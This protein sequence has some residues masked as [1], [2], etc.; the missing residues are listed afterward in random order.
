MAGRGS[1]MLMISQKGTFTQNVY[2]NFFTFA[3]SVR[4]K[5]LI[6]DFE[7][8][9]TMTYLKLSGKPF[10]YYL[11]ALYATDILFQQNNEPCSSTEKVCFYLNTK[12]KLCVRQ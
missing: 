6:L 12:R 9:K 1:T 2:P 5:T 3:S 4:Y 10:M 7:K 11:H 8:T